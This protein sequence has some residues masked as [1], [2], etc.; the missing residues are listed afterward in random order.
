MYVFIFAA[1]LEPGVVQCHTEPSGGVCDVG[2]YPTGT[3]ALAEQVAADLVGAG[4]EAAARPDVMR[5]KYT[6]LLAN[7][8]NVLQ[9]FFGQLDAVP[10][11]Y[12]ALRT[13]AEAVYAAAGVDYVPW[14]EQLA[15]YTTVL[16]LAEVNGRPFPGGSSW[17]SVVKGA[18]RV[19]TDYLNGEIALLG[20]VAGVPTP[21]NEL[22]QRKLRAF[23]RDGAATGAMN[24]DDLR[25]EMKALGANL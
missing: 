21:L 13:E 19:E 12:G 5:W 9:V 25:A 15:R 17:Q 8:G 23:V 24:P 18:A 1:A 11:L 2:R 6:K 4:F 7:L 14:D 22:V 3:D 16:P 20:H 10:D